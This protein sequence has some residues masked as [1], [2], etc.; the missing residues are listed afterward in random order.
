MKKGIWRFK[1]SR[2]I[3]SEGNQGKEMFSFQEA[4]NT[5]FIPVR[6]KQEDEVM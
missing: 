5:L 3:S 1:T 4:F 2:I 6:K